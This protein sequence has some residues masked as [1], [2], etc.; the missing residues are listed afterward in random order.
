MRSP[1]GLHAVKNWGKVDYSVSKINRINTVFSRILFGF[2]TIEN[3][4][5]V[6]NKYGIDGLLFLDGCK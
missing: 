6:C 4:S 3:N 1:F 2:L 5:V